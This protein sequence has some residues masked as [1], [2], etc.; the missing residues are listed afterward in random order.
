MRRQHWGNPTDISS[1]Q[2]LY[3]LFKKMVI[4]TVYFIEIFSVLLHMWTS[5]IENTWIVPS[6]LTHCLH[7]VHL[8]ME[9]MLWT[10]P[11]KLLPFLTGQTCTDFVLILDDWYKFMCYMYV[12]FNRHLKAD[13]LF[14]LLECVSIHVLFWVRCAIKVNYVI[15]FGQTTDICPSFTRHFLRGY[16]Q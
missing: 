8:D 16:L 6:S 3:W 14:I 11:E 5:K 10:E 1:Q 9:K 7:C 15:F 12:N 4:H 13:K 2:Q